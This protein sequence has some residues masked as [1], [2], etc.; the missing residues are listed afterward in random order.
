MKPDF[1]PIPFAKIR[2]K[3]ETSKE[4]EGKVQETNKFCYLCIQL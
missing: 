1:S 3:L 2:K 4:K